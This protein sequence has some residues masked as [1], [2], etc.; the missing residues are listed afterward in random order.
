MPLKLLILVAIFVLPLVPTFWAIQD[1]PR[2]RFATPRKKLTWFAVVSTLPFL[3]AMLYLLIARRHT[4]PAESRSPDL[5]T[6]R[7]EA[8]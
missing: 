8:R 3:G 6:D 7:E 4:Q 2:R 1:I 5:T